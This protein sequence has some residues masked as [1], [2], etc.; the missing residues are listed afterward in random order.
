MAKIFVKTVSAFLGLAILLPFVGCKDEKDLPGNEGDYA[1]EMVITLYSE[2]DESHVNPFEVYLLLDGEKGLQE[3]VVLNREWRKSLRYVSVPGKVGAIVVPSFP[4]GA[5]LD[6]SITLKY[7]VKIELALLRDGEIIDYKTESRSSE[8][9]LDDHFTPDSDFSDSYV[10]DVTTE[11]IEEVV[12]DGLLDDDISYSEP[13]P[14]K[15]NDNVKIR[16]T[17]YLMHPVDDSEDNQCLHDNLVARFTNR[18]DWKHDRLGKGDYLYIKG[19]DIALSD[20]KVI[21]E[22]LD[23]GMIVLLDDIDSFGQLSGF[24]EEMGIYNPLNGEN[25]GIP[26]SIFI[27][28]AS[29]NPF[30]SADNDS[31]YSGLFFKVSPV[32]HN[33]EFISDYSQGE[34]ADRVASI[35]NEINANTPLNTLNLSRAESPANLKTLVNA[36]KVFLCEGGY[37]HSRTKDDYRGNYAD[38]EQSNIYNV[39]FDVWNVASGDRYYYYV[40]QEFLGSFSQ[41]YKGV[42][43]TCV[44]TNGFHTMAK[45]CEWYGD[46]VTL[47]TIPGGNTRGMQIHRNSPAT[48]N[49]S[50]TY[51][52]GFSWDLSGDVSYSQGN[53]LGGTIHGGVAFSSS[54]SYTKEDISVINNCVPGQ[55]LSWSFDLRHP[56][57]SFSPVRVAGTNMREGAAAGRSSLNVGMDYIISFPILAQAP[58]V[59][60]SLDVTLRSSAGKCGCICG[61]RDHTVSCSKPI[62]LP[63][64]DSKFL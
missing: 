61:E 50:T 56:S 7:T 32:D 22:S 3:T 41:C 63:T 36:H 2:G 19:N 39:E 44:T 52:S 25:Q 16:G 17:L 30:Y 15:D 47:T 8:M 11:K 46:K 48:T 6:G 60:L 13:L 12:D 29:S 1:V 34:I 23:E 21:K 54:E 59:T 51:T 42:R 37:S 31:R 55:K 38:D 28:A 10:F 64:V 62:V 27:L 58:S 57:T 35:L 33:G 53:G 18:V 49:T 4:E 40:H 20:R 43:S 24:C 14:D 26:N 5:V 45:V 9:A